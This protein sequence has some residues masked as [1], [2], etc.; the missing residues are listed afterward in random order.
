MKLAQK[1]CNFW[2][3]FDEKL[4]F[5]KNF[6]PNPG[7]GISENFSGTH[8]YPDFFSGGYPVP[9]GTQNI[10]PWRYPVPIGTLNFFSGRYPV[11]IGTQ[12]LKFCR[13][14]SFEICS[15]PGTQRYPISQIFPVPGTQRYPNFQNFDEYRPVPW[16]PWVPEYR[17]RRHLP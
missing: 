10:S 6:D 11:P 2:S 9:I 14:P 16:Y 15:V 3:N 1:E 7:V 13:Y 17:S 8:R 4:K 5:L 12:V